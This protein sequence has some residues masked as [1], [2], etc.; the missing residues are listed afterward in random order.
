MSF[1]ASVIRRDPISRE[2]GGYVD[3]VR[4]IRKYEM[5]D[6]YRVNIQTDTCRNYVTERVWIKRNDE[7]LGRVERHRQRYYPGQQTERTSEESKLTIL[8][9]CSLHL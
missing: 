7:R 5:V 1:I 6:K 2:R 4:D 3:L 8:E 9:A